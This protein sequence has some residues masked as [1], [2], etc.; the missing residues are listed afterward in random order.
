V[1][2]RRDR[3][4]R[5]HSLE[6]IEGQGSPQRI[7]LDGLELI[8]GRAEDA[9]VRLQSQRASRHH[10]ILTRRG[11]EYAVRDN[12]SRNGV[13]LNGIKIYSAILRDGDVL[14]VADNV[15]IYRES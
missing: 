13:Y 2:A 9:Q 10:A 8:I 7:K 11:V 5:P 14:Q 12:D 4:I 3:D 6:K 1:A 15:F